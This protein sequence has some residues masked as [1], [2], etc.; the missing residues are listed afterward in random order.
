M[1]SVSYFEPDMYNTTN[2]KTSNFSDHNT[3]SQNKIHHDIP[4]ELRR[5]DCTQKSKLK[6][7]SN[8]WPHLVTSINEE[9]ILWLTYGDLS[10]FVP[11]P[12]GIKAVLQLKCTDPPAYKLWNR[13]IRAEIK[14]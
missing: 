3:Q 6:Y 7:T 13:A 5:S 1:D 12:K 8:D 2:N 11:E 4:K 9:K 14:N 10:M